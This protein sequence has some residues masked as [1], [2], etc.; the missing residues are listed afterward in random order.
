MD[1]DVLIKPFARYADFGLIQKYNLV[2]FWA[3]E[4]LVQ[5][6]FHEEWFNNKYNRALKESDLR[7]LL[8]TNY[9][10]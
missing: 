4:I 8:K 6:A 2:Q 1:I 9:F 10:N 3:I 7:A 5:K